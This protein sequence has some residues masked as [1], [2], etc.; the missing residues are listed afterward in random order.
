DQ[1]VDPFVAARKVEVAR[2]RLDGVVPAL[3][4]FIGFGKRDQRLRT[5]GA[6]VG[7]F[8]QERERS[9]QIIGAAQRLAVAVL[10]SALF[11][12]LQRRP[13]AREEILVELGRACGRTA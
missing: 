10:V 1:E 5:G 12:T 2:L 3:E 8:R 6:E 13:E 11:L 9:F 7:G 4:R